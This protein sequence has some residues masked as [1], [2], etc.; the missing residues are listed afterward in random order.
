MSPRPRKFEDEELFSALVRVMMRVGPTQ[1]TLA[2]IAQE[3]GVTAAALVQ[4]FGS[5]RQMMLAHARYAARAGD[6]GL[7]KPVQRKGSALR[8]IRA[9]IA[10]YAELAASP[11]AALRNL[12]YLQ[13]DLAEP[14]LHANLLRMS[15]AA[16]RH[17]E[18]LITE[19]VDSG[20]LLPGTSSRALSRAI[21]V[22]LVGSY[23][24]WAIYREGSAKKWLRE[25]L[26]AV[27]RPHLAHKSRAIA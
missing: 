21:E 6:I 23:L 17:Y 9:T 1:L 20:E 18:G 2:A 24:S 14:A 13:R 22:T 11:E 3:A 7:V 12:A 16:R 15:R 26:N 19:A 10:P 4:R 5:K 27:L 25:D 8:A